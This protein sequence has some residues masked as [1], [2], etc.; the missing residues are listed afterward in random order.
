MLE[1]VHYDIKNE[2]GNAMQPIV[3]YGEFNDRLL[4]QGQQGLYET[5]IRAAHC[6]MIRRYWDLKNADVTIP[7]ERR[8]DSLISQDMVLKENRERL[9]EAI[10]L[11]KRK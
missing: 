5:E 7:D 10:R 11:L 6:D 2:L 8:L 9:F 3:T 4:S 1:T